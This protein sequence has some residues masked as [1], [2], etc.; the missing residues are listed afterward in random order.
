MRRYRDREGIKYD[1]LPCGLLRRRI[2]HR[3]PSPLPA[4]EYRAEIEARV[5]RLAEISPVLLKGQQ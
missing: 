4:P 2:P 5:G 3:D 1:E